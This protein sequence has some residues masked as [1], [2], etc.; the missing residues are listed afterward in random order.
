MRC[1]YASA[2]RA[3]P[4]SVVP[5]REKNRSTHTHVWVT[6]HSQLWPTRDWLAICQSSKLRSC[7]SFSCV[8]L[9]GTLL[10]WASD[11]QEAG[12][13]WSDPF[14]QSSQHHPALLNCSALL[15]IPSVSYLFHLRWRILNLTTYAYNRNSYKSSV[16]LRV[17]FKGLHK[18]FV[19][20]ITPFPSTL[21]MTLFEI[22]LLEPLL[23]KNKQPML[24]FTKHK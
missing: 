22:D 3:R 23:K 24:F 15:S 12:F 21:G 7:F 17:E 20:H 16:L 8:K 19:A 9:N 1:T 10:W 13:L 18:H 4:W 14:M 2:L 6:P 11:R 5:G